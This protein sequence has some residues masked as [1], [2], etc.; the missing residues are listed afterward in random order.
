M[1]V[2]VYELEISPKIDCIDIEKNGALE[3]GAC[4]PVCVCVKFVYF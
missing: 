2:F 3:C 4:L 1:F